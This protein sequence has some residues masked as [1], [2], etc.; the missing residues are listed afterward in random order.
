[1]LVQSSR[2]S[3]SLSSSRR[4]VPLASALSTPTMSRNNSL[5]NYDHQQQQQQE[6]PNT[7]NCNT[8]PVSSVLPSSTPPRL[9]SPTQVPSTVELSG[10]GGVEPISFSS[11]QLLSP[12]KAT[13]RRTRQ[14]Y[15]QN[16]GYIMDAK[17]KG[18]V[19][20]YINVSTLC[21]VCVC[22]C[23]REREMGFKFSF[24]FLPHLSYST[25]VVQT[26][27]YKTCSL[28]LMT[29]GFHGWPSLQKSKSISPSTPS[30]L[31]IFNIPP[32]LPITSPPADVSRRCRS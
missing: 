12:R 23:G 15:G 28:I 1:M 6:T 17:T 31:H 3:L 8:P 32:P 18:N 7:S 14:Y 30:P 16:S 13:G 5:N 11:A 25:A 19:G 9:M 20:R 22:V 4:P 24:F 21:C 10:D 2:F 27:L 29:F 26:C